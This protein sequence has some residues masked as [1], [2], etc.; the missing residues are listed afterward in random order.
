M[1]TVSEVVRLGY[2]VA[3]LVDPEGTGRRMTGG[4]L[5]ARATLAARVLGARHV[6]QAL[7][8]LSH[9]TRLVRRMGQATDLLHAASMGALAAYDPA[10]R[11]QALT[12]GTVALA[13]AAAG[14]VGS[15]ST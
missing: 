12:D 3:L 7:V 15:P 8:S 13:F 5:D 10:R 1:A 9:G 11:R 4:P 14:Q 6:V 2:G